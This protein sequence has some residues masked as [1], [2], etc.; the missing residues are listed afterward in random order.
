MNQ[1]TSRFQLLKPTVSFGTLDPSSGSKKS[2]VGWASTSG[3]AG[4]KQGCNSLEVA[5]AFQPMAE[6]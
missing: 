1:P 6:L 2:E 3:K 4:Q 5:L